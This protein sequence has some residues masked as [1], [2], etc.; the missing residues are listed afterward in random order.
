MEYSFQCFTCKKV[1]VT[2]H[3]MS[4]PHPTHHDECGGVLR[5]LFI[6]PSVHYH[7]SGYYSTDK[8]LSTTRKDDIYDHE[9]VGYSGTDAIQ[10]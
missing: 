6:A 3:A 4:E 5:R 10:S 7:G 1:V 2:K 8:A 9:V